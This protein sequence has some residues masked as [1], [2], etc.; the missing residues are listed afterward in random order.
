VFIPPTKLD[1][2]FWTVV[3][4]VRQGWSILLSAVRGLEAQNIGEDSLG[5]FARFEGEEVHATGE[6]Y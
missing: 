3:D 1:D 4:N 5:V 2:D 6:K